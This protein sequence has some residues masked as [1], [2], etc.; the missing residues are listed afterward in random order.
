MMN[1][2]RFLQDVYLPH[3]ARALNGKLCDEEHVLYDN[4][5]GESR[6]RDYKLCVEN[7]PF[8]IQ[9]EYAQNNLR[10]MI[11]STVAVD[12]CHEHILE[13]LAYGLIR[14]TK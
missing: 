12:E 8:N 2:A 11:P 4:D 10:N 9:T 3:A 6:R 5:Q 14:F 1:S 13:F 7:A